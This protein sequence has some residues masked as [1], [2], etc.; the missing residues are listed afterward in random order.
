[1]IYFEEGKGQSKGVFS[2]Q[3]KGKTTP[4]VFGKLRGV[5]KKGRQK[6]EIN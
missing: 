6:R 3:N 2:M 4:F 5:K 1:M